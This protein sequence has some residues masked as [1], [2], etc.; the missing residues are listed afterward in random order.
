MPFGSE[1]FKNDCTIQ[2]QHLTFS[3]VGAHHQNAVAER[4]IRT[5]TGWARTMMLHSIIHWPNQGNLELWLFAMDHAAYF[6]ITYLKKE[7]G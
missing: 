4:A 5:I 3:G 7:L 2:N 6:G 1:Q